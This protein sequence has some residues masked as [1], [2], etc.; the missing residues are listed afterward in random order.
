MGNSDVR[1]SLVDRCREVVNQQ[2]QRR[3]KEFGDRVVEPGESGPDIGLSTD[4]VEDLLRRAMA[5]TGHGVT[6]GV[7]GDGPVRL[8][9]SH[10]DSRLLV[11][12]E[13]ASV[14]VTDGLVV[15]T[16]PVSCDETGTAEVQ[17]GL[18]V[19]SKQRP[20][21]MV[22]VAGEPRGPRPIVELWGEALTA[23]AW[24]ALLRATTDLARHAGRDLDGY[25]LIPAGLQAGD[26]VTLAT[27]A[28]HEIDRRP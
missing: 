22:A 13:K 2:R 18:A 20:A 27:A 21:G 6:T 11:G 14:A 5:E 26:G 16:V 28:R 3:P 24:G 9:W 17:I 4:A 25:G 1:G 15:V 10:E 8:L 7:S 19:G 12:V 23:L